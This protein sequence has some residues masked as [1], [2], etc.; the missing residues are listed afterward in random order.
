MNQAIKSAMKRHVKPQRWDIVTEVF[1]L[2]EV[3]TSCEWRDKY[4]DC[5]LLEGTGPS[6]AGFCP[7]YEDQIA[8]EGDE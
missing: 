2:G 8:K 6:V 7:G 1:D 4:G 5:R 3:C